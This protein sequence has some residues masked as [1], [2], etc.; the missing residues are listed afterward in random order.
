MLRRSKRALSFALIIASSV[1]APM[2]EAG[3]VATPMATVSLPNSSPL[4][5]FRLLF[6]VGA[7]SDP[8]GKEGLATLTAG[9]DICPA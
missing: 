9:H 3:K 1:F 5:T 7:A 2:A 4:V 6:N 8:K